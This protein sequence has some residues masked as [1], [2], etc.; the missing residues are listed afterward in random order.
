MLVDFEQHFGAQGCA[1]FRENILLVHEHVAGVDVVEKVPDAE[2]E[3]VRELA[4]LAVFGDFVDFLSVEHVR[5]VAVENE[6]AD[7]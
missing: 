6:G 4:H 2:A 1:E 3:V 7:V 5:F